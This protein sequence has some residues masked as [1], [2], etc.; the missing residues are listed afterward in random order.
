M[1][2][3]D[4][5][6]VLNAD[7]I[8]GYRYND[9]QKR[10]VN[11]VY[12]PKQGSL[13]IV[14]V[15]KG[16]RAGGSWGLCSIW[17]A[18]MF[19]SK[20]PL[21]KD[22]SPFDAKWPFRKSAR[23]AAPL[24]SLEDKGPLQTA[25][26]Q[27][28]PAG[29]YS[30]TKGS[31]KGY[32][33]QGETVTGWSW[34]AMTYDQSSQQAAGANLGLVL[35]SEPPPQSLFTECITRLSGNGM[36]IAEF[37]RL[38]LSAF[39]D[40]YVEA[41]ALLLDG[42]KVGEVRVVTADIEDSCRDHHNGHQAHSAIEAT[43]AAWPQ[44]E[45]EARRTGKPL[46]LSGRIYPKWGEENEIEVLPEYHQ[47]CWEQGKVR[48][49]S[50]L[51]PHDRKPWAMGWF[52]TFPNEDVIA[53]C[54]WPPFDFHTSKSSPINHIED[55]RGVILETEAE[56]W[57]VVE[58]RIDPNFGQA[59]KAGTGQSVRTM[60]AM[61]CRDCTKNKE[62]ENKCEHKLF[63]G[64]SPDAINDGHALVRSA[65]GDSS[66]GVRPKLFAL[67]SA[68]PNICRGMRRYAYREFKDEHRG[69]SEAP[70][71]VSKDFPDV[72]RY[73]FLS[74]LDKW[75][76]EPKPIELWTPPTRRARIMRSR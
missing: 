53:I 12:N 21:F 51:D 70:E 9:A 72:V 42:K 22:K 19:G 7:P 14:L 64:L 57:P 17:S 47:E 69:T 56:L 50:V 16:N 6:A 54:E 67:K 34:G 63:Y 61:P 4:F 11:A 2:H 76:A 66:A 74:R 30:Q 73:T 25:M 29:A 28:F 49:S 43:I 75:P 71:M 45:R 35:M 15:L 38:D 23:L 59:P 40:E 5:D 44:E 32:Y 26:R 24:G 41:G 68:C 3:E 58:R 48:I 18:I 20:H 55:Y 10:F 65:I 31:G 39:I 60:L 52:A 37:T 62:F 1:G 8:M 36:L 27:L 33:A 46:N 13:T